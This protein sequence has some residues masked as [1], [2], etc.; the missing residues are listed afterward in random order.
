MK[1][2]TVTLLSYE[3]EELLEALR[4]DMR[5]EQA[6]ILDDPQHRDIHQL[7]YRRLIRLLEAISP[8]HRDSDP[9]YVAESIF[10]QRRS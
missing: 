1:L 9:T 6:K 7:N 3:Y 10:A 2:E 5:S 8:R 4:R